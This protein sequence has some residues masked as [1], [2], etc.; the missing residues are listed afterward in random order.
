MSTSVIYYT[1]QIYAMKQKEAFPLKYWRGY[2]VAFIFAAI[3]WVLMQYGQ[4]FTGLVD[5][6]LYL[7]PAGTSAILKI[8]SEAELISSTD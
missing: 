3:T 8:L 5:M 7:P 1:E 4:Q 6:V 2:L